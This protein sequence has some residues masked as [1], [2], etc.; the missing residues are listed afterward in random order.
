MDYQRG[1][2]IQAALKLKST[3][4]LQR[5]W[6]A[7]D[8]GDWTP[9][10]VEFARQII[11]ERGAPLEAVA[12][13]SQPRTDG[14]HRAVPDGRHYRRNGAVIGFLAGIAIGVGKVALGTGSSDVL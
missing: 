4:E 7:R 3:E 8:R 6:A 2:D 9:E 1:S 14:V 10:A 5:V 13:E 12:A 11:A